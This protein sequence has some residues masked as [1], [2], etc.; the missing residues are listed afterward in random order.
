MASPTT[1]DSDNEEEECRVCRCPSTPS[2]PLFEPCLCNGSISKIHQQCLTAWLSHSKK[3]SCELCKTPFAFTPIYAANAPSVVSAL[4]VLTV[5][6]KLSLSTALPLLL[7]LTACVITWLILVPIATAY[8]YRLWM[9]RGSDFLVRYNLH[10]VIVRSDRLMLFSPITVNATA[11]T[12]MTATYTSDITSG[13][14]IN[15]LVLLTFL[16][17]MSF[18]DFLRW[19]WDLLPDAEGDESDYESGEEEEEE[20]PGKHMVQARS[21]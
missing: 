20:A 8:V 15:L 10:S 14:F 6:T 18:A 21:C 2:Q 11:I 12:S 19:N 17:L 9:S 4:Q 5:H 3:S 16:S 1:I 13:I 7:R